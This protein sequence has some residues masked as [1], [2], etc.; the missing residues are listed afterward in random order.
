ME[1]KPFA[2]IVDNIESITRIDFQIYSNDFN[3][4]RSAVSDP[5]GITVAELYDNE[6]VHSV[7]IKCY[8]CEESMYYQNEINPFPTGHCTR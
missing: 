7:P 6:P 5:N 4:K 1:T 8:A 3:P 2:R